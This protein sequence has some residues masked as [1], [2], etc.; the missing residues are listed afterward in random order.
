MMNRKYGLFAFFVAAVVCVLASGCATPYQRDTG[1]G[2]TGGYK[3]THIKDNTYYV[4]IRVNV[5]AG[6]L[7]AVEYLNRRARELCME[8]GFNDYRIYETTDTSGYSITVSHG[9]YVSSGGVGRQP[10][11]AGYVDCLKPKK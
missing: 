5:D 7:K 3:D 8:N 2:C 11:I 9:P 10:G 4:Q 1:F 6:Q